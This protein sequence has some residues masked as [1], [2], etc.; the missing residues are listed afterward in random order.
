MD[1]LLS[2]DRHSQRSHFPSKIS[3]KLTFALRFQFIQVIFQFTR[4]NEEDQDSQ[5][6]QNSKDLKESTMLLPISKHE[7]ELG[8]PISTVDTYRVLGKQF[9]VPRDSFVTNSR[10][11]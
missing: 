11:F 4:N 2:C 6:D 8:R 9:S 10:T 3:E 5:E 7:T 1:D